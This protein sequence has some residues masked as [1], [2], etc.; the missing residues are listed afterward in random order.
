MRKEL[1]KV[2]FDSGNLFNLMYEALKWELLK[3]AIKLN[4]F[5]HCKKATTAAEVAKTLSLHPGNAEHMLNALVALG[6]LTKTNNAYQNTPQ[7]ETFLTSGKETSLGPALLFM[8]KWTLPLLNGGLL[9]LVKN[10]PPPPKNMA[11]P[12]LWE[13]AA[14]ASVNHVRCGRAQL[15]AKHVS[16]LPEFASFS[17]ILDMGSGPGVIGIAVAAAHPSLE[18]TLMDRP[19]VCKV[20]NET[21]SEYGMEDRVS[22]R[23]GDYMTDDV[24][25]K[26]DFIMANFTLNFYRDR[27]DEIMRKVHG[28]LNPGGVFMVT[29]DGMRRDGTGPAA[30]V[31]SWLPTT[32]QGNDMS[33]GTGRIACAM[34]DAG[35]VSTEL[36]TLTDIELEAHGPVEMTIGRKAKG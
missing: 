12:E 18:C 5:D 15:I 19:P 14:R 35:F 28:S 3:A 32:L 8:E 16:E 25:M 26:F 22:A 23:P 20:I 24:G 13:Q 4:L 1:P 27:L 9:E 17:R 11:T 31:I 21:I 6:C 34:L 7:T 33:L 30:S 36:R 2:A 10:G 29:S